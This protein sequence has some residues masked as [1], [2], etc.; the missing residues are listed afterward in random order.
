MNGIHLTD[1]NNGIGFLI[2]FFYGK[3]FNLE[4]L[5]IVFIFWLY[6]FLPVQN[7]HIQYGVYLKFAF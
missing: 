1:Q 3:P 2:T 5:H 6:L 7:I 4:T